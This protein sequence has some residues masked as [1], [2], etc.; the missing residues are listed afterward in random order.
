M[1]K[2]KI[3]FITE[4]TTSWWAFEKEMDI[5]R[6]DGFECFLTDDLVEAKKI[7]DTGIDKVVMF[8][9][10]ISYDNYEINPGTAPGKELKFLAGYCFWKQDLAKRNIPTMIVNIYQSDYGYIADIMTI[11]QKEDWNTDPNVVFMGSNFDSPS[12]T[13][14]LVELI[15]A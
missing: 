3:L 11:L 8:P 1:T 9:I 15:K 7:L 4:H 6:T 12:T 14:K 5:L 13:Q 10:A 2:K